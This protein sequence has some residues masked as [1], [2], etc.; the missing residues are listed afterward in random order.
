MLREAAFM[1]GLGAGM[2][3]QGK[4]KM[5]EAAL[6]HVYYNI[7]RVRKTLESI[8]YKPE[9]DT[10]ERAPA[11]KSPAAEAMGKSAGRQ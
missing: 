2:N 8:G 1:I 4:I 9:A 6:N 7:P 5:L 11:A 3:D 10:A